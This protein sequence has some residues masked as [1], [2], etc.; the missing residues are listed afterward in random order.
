MK[1]EA[2]CL[3]GEEH[4]HPKNTVISRLF[5]DL[6]EENTNIQSQ[7]AL[8]HAETKTE[9]TFRK[10]NENANALARVLLQTM[11]KEGMKPNMDGDYI[12]ALRFI[13]DESLI[14]TILALFKAGLAYVPL[15]PNWPEGRIQHIIKEAEPVMVITNTKSNILFK[16]QK[17]LSA[18]KKR[19]IYQYD[20]LFKE[21]NANISISFN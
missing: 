7:V 11:K 17:G 9:V 14:T 8:V 16:A 19:H 6:L 3:Q 2:W 1:L 18:E 13:P 5:E 15:A 12:V 4:D 21:I 20:E 10:L